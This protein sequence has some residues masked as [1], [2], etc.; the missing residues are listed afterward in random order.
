[1]KFKYLCYTLNII[2]VAKNFFGG[3]LPPSS[4]PMLLTALTATVVLVVV[5]VTRKTYIKTYFADFCCA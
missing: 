4:S 1:M 2:R 3:E 5:E